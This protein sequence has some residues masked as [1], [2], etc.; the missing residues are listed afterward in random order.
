[1]TNI[2]FTTLVILVLSFPGYVLRG[3]YYAGKFTSHVLPRN[4]TE[5]IARAIL[6]SLPLHLTMLSVFE[7][8]QYS[9]VIHTTLIFEAV[10][11]VLAG[12]YDDNISTIIANLYANTRYVISYYMSTLIVALGLGYALRKIVWKW[13]WDVKYPWLFRYKNEWLYTLMGRDVPVPPEYSEA[14]IYVRVEALTKIPLQEETARTRLYRGIVEGFTTEDSG[15]LRDILLT[16]VERGK[17]RKEP[18]K[19][20]EFYWKP[21]TPGNLMILKYS[22]LQN[23]NITYLMELPPSSSPTEKTV[24]TQSFRSG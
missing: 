10:F 16:E 4:W 9:G 15:A 12:E 3:S 22:E 1:M 18:A 5:D 20:P 13:K 6:I 8:L 14:K 7:W 11:R 24:A 23:V 21:V 17:F 2:A 19:E